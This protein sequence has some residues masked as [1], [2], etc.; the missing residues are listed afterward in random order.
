M[1]IFLRSKNLHHNLLKVRFF[2]LFGQLSWQICVVTKNFNAYQNHS[3]YFLLRHWS[4]C[5][6]VCPSLDA[7]KIPASQD[8]D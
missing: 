7:E 5:S 4:I 8:D 1:D 6:S 2:T 3:H